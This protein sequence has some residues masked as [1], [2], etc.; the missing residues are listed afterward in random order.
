MK[1]SAII[2]TKNEEENI[3][4]CIKTLTFADE[5]V[6]VDNNSIDSTV[7]KAKTAGA[8]T[9]V[10]SGLDFSYLR[11]VGKEKASSEWIL[12]IDADE[13]VTHELGKE[14]AHAINSKYKY[15][16]YSLIRQNYFL[17]KLWPKKEKMLRLIKKSNLIGWQGSLHETPLV[18]GEIRELKGALL[19]YTHRD[20]SSMV[21][22]TN[23]WSDIEAQLRFQNDHP[24]MRWW[25]FLRV[26]ITA[27]WRSYVSDEGWKVGTVGLI[28]SIYQSFSM[29][30]TYAKL[31]EKQNNMKIKNHYK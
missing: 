23:E 16:G 2:I 3:I 9:Y 1:L 12:Y 29:F 25:R 8:L 14:I 6:V 28:E 5:V 4:D 31:W 30:I 20:I 26:M 7:K 18:S 10:V 22:K 19:H 27:F 21:I 11:N 15:I 17:G 24:S 13:R